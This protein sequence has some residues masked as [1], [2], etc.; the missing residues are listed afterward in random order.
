MVKKN[1]RLWGHLSF[2]TNFPSI[3]IIRNLFPSYA[4]LV[5]LSLRIFCK[6]VYN[7]LNHVIFYYRLLCLVFLIHSLH[8]LPLLF[9]FS[10]RYFP[11]FHNSYSCSVY[12]GY[13]IFASGF[14]FHF[15]ETLQIGILL[16]GMKAFSPFVN[17]HFKLTPQST[18]LV[19]FIV[20]L[21]IK[22]PSFFALKIISMGDY[23]YYGTHVLYYKDWD[24]TEISGIFLI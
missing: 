6:P 18:S 2:L 20:C 12:L 16:N 24:S 9:C 10:P 13:N 15:G 8:N 19:F 5:R 14:M 4:K 1:V 7:R 3:S 22:I 17:R 11:S 21:L 23:Y